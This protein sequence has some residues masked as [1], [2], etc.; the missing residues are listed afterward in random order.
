[1]GLLDRARIWAARG[2]VRDALMTVEAARQVL[3]SAASPALLAQAG[4]QCAVTARQSAPRR[5]LATLVLAP[6]F[7]HGWRSGG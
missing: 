4:R 3:T 2:Q 6:G 1:L 5:R 7:S